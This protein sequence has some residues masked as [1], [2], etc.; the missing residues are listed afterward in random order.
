M[1]RWT[2]SFALCIALVMLLPLSV[3][4]QAIAGIVTDASGSVL[5]GV[6][7]EASSGALIEQT[8]SV[9][10]NDA[11]RFSIVNLRP[12]TYTVTFTLGGFRTVRREG[13][14]LTSDFTANIN[15]E[16]GVGGIE[17]VIT[18]AAVAPV[19][20][21][22][23]VAAPRVY[24]RDMLD[25]LPTGRTPAAILNTIPGTSPGFFATNFRGTSDSVTMV[26]GM[27]ASNL[28]GAGPSLTTAPS[29]SSM[30]QE[31]SFS[32]NIDSAEVG[33]PG[34]RI[35]L[36][37]KDGGNQLRGSI[38]ST[39][40]R[41]DWQS[42]NIDDYL[43]SQGL[44]EP[45]KTIKLWDFNPSVGGPIA[46]DRLW[47][48][49]TYQNN[50]SDTQVVGSFYD[51]D[52]SPYAYRA[53][54]SRP[55]VNINRA[56]SFVQRLTW[57]GS[58]KDKVAGH[59]ERQDS[60]TPYFGSPLLGINP[61]PESTLALA[62]PSNDQVGARWTRTHTSRLLLETSYLWSQ[63]DTNNNY[64]DGLEPW[65][66]RFLEDPGVPSR[67]GMTSAPA[68]LAI[69][70]ISTQQLIGGAPSV[71]DANASN[72][73]ELR[74]TA[75]Y[76]TG[77]HSIKG[78][79]S[80]LRG[81]YHRPAN[82]VGD[83]VLNYSGG[84]P[85][86]IVA[87]V[88]TNRRDDIDGDWAFFVQDR[89]TVGRMTANVGLRMDWLMTSYPDQLLP[90]NLWVA[91]ASCASNRAFCGAD[92]LNWKDLSPRLGLAYDLFG[93]GK[94]A[95]KA[96]YSR[97]VAGETV[98]LTGAVNP[99]LAISTTDTRVWTDLNADKSIFNSN[100]SLQTTEIG[101]SRNP[102]FGTPVPVT[103]YDPDVLRGW[104]KRGYSWEGN[105]SIQ[106]EL[107]PRLGLG[108]LYYRRTQGNIRVTDN[109][110]ITPAD[111]S[112]PFCVAVPPTTLPAGN[113]LPGDVIGSQQCG[114]Y[115][116]N[117]VR[118]PQNYVTFA[119]TL[120]VDRTDIVTGYE[121]S[122]NA[123]LAQAFISGG[124]NFNNQHLNFQAG[125]L[126]CDFIDSPEV[127][128]CETD[129]SYR[130]DL[131]LNGSYLLPYDVQVS[132]TY[133]G[134]AG[135][136]A[137]ANWAATNAVITPGLGRPLTSGATKTI[138]LM[139]P[140]TEFFSMRHVFDMRFSKL[141]RANRY[142]FQVMTDFFNIFNTNAV[143][144]INTTFGANLHKPTLVETPRQFRFSGQFEF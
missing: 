45:P 110:A 109:R 42:S 122:V 104:F 111:F 66:A 99:S 100:G 77:S 34:I 115:D 106:H 130:P 15:A 102:A 70:E 14:E 137:I 4:A 46:R 12:G 49:T 123:R 58:Q 28:I 2:R 114:L 132:A 144:A 90:G 24:T 94:T 83:V 113:M 51:A 38:F 74:S 53:D 105:V 138:A 6:T 133:R 136:Q 61:P 16:L 50:G 140:G 56:Y 68:A 134:L 25:A 91:E 3:S 126:A 47:F 48:Q 108:A 135:P 128:F 64:R 59:Y 71:S 54:S 125:S 78:G 55:A 43:R 92:V 33:Q 44:T 37:P 21:V 143:S 85:L 103:T 65:S 121:I 41:D 142:R 127:R 10:T 27:R 88:P 117:V 81:S 129:T 62:V 76:V 98:N 73:W 69:L 17:E 93:N 101:P 60:K 36:I 139:E 89:W 11:G 57:Q 22:Q 52:P 26:D 39:Y 18:V 30:Y 35:N 8:R 107:F 13:I 84:N 23:S 119:D 72:S 112:G 75:T 141:F 116:V 67:T 1:T 97:F 20:D 80:L 19:V 79:F 5:P 32:T 120:D 131:K 7:V 86:Q 40:T 31:Y 118:A 63:R 95:I 9:V 124:V 29:S 87:T 82:V 96:A